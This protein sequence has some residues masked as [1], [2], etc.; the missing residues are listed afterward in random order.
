VEDIDFSDAFCRF[1]Q[2]QLPSVD[3][4]E[5]LLV[6]LNEPD[7]AWQAKA[8]VERLP[9]GVNLTE[10]DAA[11]HLQAFQAAGLLDST[12]RYRPA[13]PELGG[14]VETLAKAYEERP[15]TLIRLIYALRDRKI[16][17]FADAFKLRRD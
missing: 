3:A 14:F 15:V 1:V 11:K 16:R 6:V 5:L 8:A 4:A 13:T 7:V 9:A 10:A 2:V 12:L 17:S